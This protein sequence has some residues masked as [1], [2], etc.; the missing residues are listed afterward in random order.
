[1]FF[2]YLKVKY[3]Y[4]FYNVYIIVV[5]NIL[6][7]LFFYN[8]LENKNGILIYKFFIFVMVLIV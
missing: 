5:L 8:W 3:F 7:L 1:M 6:L 4:C 2:C